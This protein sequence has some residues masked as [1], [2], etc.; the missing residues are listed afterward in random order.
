MSEALHTDLM[1]LSL[2]GADE[3][4]HRSTDENQQPASDSEQG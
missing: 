2:R 4:E 1:T 3:E